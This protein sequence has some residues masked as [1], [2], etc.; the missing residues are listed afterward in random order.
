MKTDVYKYAGVISPGGYTRLCK[1]IS[2]RDRSKKALL[3]IATPGG[4]PN[5]GFRIARALQHE[6]EDGFDALVPRYCKSAGTMILLGARQIFMANQSELGP[7]DIQIKKGDELFGRSSGLDMTQAVSFLRG[8]AIV[9]FN[10]YMHKL[11]Q[12]GLSTKVAAEISVK[13]VQ[14][15]FNPIA[16]QIEPLRLAEMQRA[17]AI[18][19]SYGAR[20]MDTGKNVLPNGLEQLVAGY[21]SHAFVIDRKEARTI[22]SNVH[23]PTAALDRLCYDFTKSHGS[24]V[25]DQNPTVDFESIE[26]SDHPKGAP[27][28]EAI[29][30]TGATASSAG[31]S[32]PDEHGDGIATRRNSTSRRPR[33]RAGK[34][35]QSTGE[36]SSLSV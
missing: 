5:A 16:A 32:K 20:L 34:S 2:E 14:G 3:V 4:D 36:A 27:N 24:K 15:I 25:N 11:V 10:D 8:E 33:S 13:L 12:Q 28:E 7:L 21:P 30:P 22:F 18:T 29:D 9:S 26:L 31:A 23:S 1:K 19:L 35:S 6:Y 17:A